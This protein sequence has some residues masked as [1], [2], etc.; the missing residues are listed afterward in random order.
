MASKLS[1]DAFLRVIAQSG[2]LTSD[3]LNE[4]MES[5]Q[6][7]G[8]DVSSTDAVAN[9]LVKRESLTSW[10]ADKLLQGKHKGFFLGKYRLL[11]LLG[12][13]GMS[14]VYLA[15]H[16]LMRRRCAIKVLP[17]KRVHDSSY[18]GRFHREAQAVAALDH[19]NI[20]RAYDVDQEINKN[21]EIHFL[22]MEYVEGSSLQ[23]LVRD[24]GLQGYEDSVEYCRQTA[25]GLQHAH[26]AGMVHRD[27]KPGN[28]LVD[29]NG[30]VKILDLGLARFF[31]EGETESLTVA[32]DEKVL[33]TADYLAPEQA[34][35]S[36]QVDAR[37]DIYSLGCTLYFMLTG[38]PPFTDG[39]L[40]QRLMSHQRKEPPPISDERQDFPGHLDQILK[41]M[42]KKDPDDRYESAEQLAEV[43]AVWLDEHASAEW[44]SQ[45]PGAASGKLPPA[46]AAEHAEPTDQNLASFLENLNN[47]NSGMLERSSSPSAELKTADEK[48]SDS[49][50]DD[51]RPKV[52]KPIQ[53]KPV[54]ARKKESPNEQVVVE[55][56]ASKAAPTKTVTPSRVKSP[57]DRV[58]PDTDSPSESTDTK[59]DATRKKGKGASPSSKKSKV[60]GNSGTGRSGK[61]DSRVGIGNEPDDVQGSGNLVTG[62]QTQKL[63]NSFLARENRKKLLIPVAGVVALLIVSMIVY[64]VWPSSDPTN[65]TEIGNIEQVVIE[66]NPFDPNQPMPRSVTVGTT[67]DFKS[68]TSAIAHAKTSFQSA[69]PSDILTITLQP[70]TYKDRIVLDATDKAYLKNIHIV[71]EQPGSAVLKPEGEEPVIRISRGR[72]IVIEGLKIDAGD[73]AIA[74][75][76]E[77]TLEG[78]RL[79][80]L[81]ITGFTGHGILTNSLSGYQGDTN[82]VHFSQ[83]KIHSDKPFASG[84]TLKGAEIY[85]TLVH[86]ENSR[87]FGKMKSGITIAGN[88][89]NLKIYQS[90]FAGLERGITFEGDIEDL[91]GM[92]VAN[93]TFYETESPIY[94]EQIPY[95]VNN[96]LQLFRNLF[97]K[98]KQEEVSLRQKLTPGQSQEMHHFLTV[99]RNWSDRPMTG[100][101]PAEGEM[102]IFE[103]NGKQGDLGIELLSTDPASPDYLKPKLNPNVVV[104]KIRGEPIEAQP[105][106]GAVDPRPKPAPKSAPKTTPPANNKPQPAANNP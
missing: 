6:Q 11:S 14:S 96:E 80:D 8:I 62:S 31:G 84:I 19:P 29:T 25:L 12:K 103:N 34:L 88:S 50:A 90:I 32:H 26:A 95:T 52:A 43:L 7:A 92:L 94:F 53:A 93:N 54:T 20:V 76:L 91:W 85:T 102:N 68:L 75:T 101:P 59:L 81:E 104:R 33:G 99:G 89:D 55:T 70:G 82:E 60:R 64:S 40:A 1:V 49:R 21:A 67:G 41:K 28:L 2:L 16:V 63:S 38:H 24:E 30:I 83:L 69:G 13:G 46:A 105:F 86:I 98:P 56:A 23:E 100:K 74:V 77:N 10:Q 57:A 48:K 27:I 51:P 73:N 72:D 87:F 47:E 39:T 17:A 106:I 9:A 61:I 37:A 44:K 66:E 97:L 5:L 58:A 65:D 18:L 15:E 3:K 35:D 42:M 22:V 79:Q 71:A 45:H 4:A 36:H 78:L